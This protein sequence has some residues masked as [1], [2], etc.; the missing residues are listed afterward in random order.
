MVGST[1]VSNMPA[2][3]RGPSLTEDA[4]GRCCIGEGYNRAKGRWTRINSISRRMGQHRGLKV[5]HIICIVYLNQ[6]HCS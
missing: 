1:V 6:D 2:T 5:K 4:G 3:D